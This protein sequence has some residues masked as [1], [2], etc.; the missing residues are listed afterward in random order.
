M[1]GTLKL[2]EENMKKIKENAETRMA[3]HT[4]TVRPDRCLI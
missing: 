1:V 4:H 2:K 3:V